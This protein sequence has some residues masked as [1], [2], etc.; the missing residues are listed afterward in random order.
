MPS[1]RLSQAPDCGL[2]GSH[3]SRDTEYIAMDC[4]NHRHA[5][6]APGRDSTSRRPTQHLLP[7]AHRM[8]PAL[9]LFVLATMSATLPAR[10]PVTRR[11]PPTGAELLESR[12]EWLR[13]S[14]FS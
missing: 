2:L 14:Y 5:S 11:A 4:T 10:E 1:H 3:P 9:A 6:I 7:R 12:H 8:V 13:P